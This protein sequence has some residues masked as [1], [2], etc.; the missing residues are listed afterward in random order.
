MREFSFEKLIVWEKSRQLAVE[1]YK[2][3]KDFPTEER[4]GLTSQIRRCS[5]SVSSNIAEGSG[6]NSNKDK[7]RFTEIAFSSLM[8]LLNQLIITQDLQLIDKDTYFE[9]RLQIEEI[10][11]M[12]NALRKTQLNS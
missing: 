5:I 11:R 2:I 3:T 4:F 1:V 9:L 12:L 8:E 7:V 10:G 6:R